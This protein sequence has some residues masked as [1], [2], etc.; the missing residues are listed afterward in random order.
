MFQGVEIGSRF[1]C[2]VILGRFVRLEKGRRGNERYDISVKKNQR[3]TT[4]KTHEA[5]SE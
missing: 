3:D 4:K 5:K 1:D 2:F